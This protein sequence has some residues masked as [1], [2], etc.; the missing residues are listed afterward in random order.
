MSA[1]LA[2]LLP[3]AQWDPSSD[4][5]LDRFLNDAGNPAFLG[6][7]TTV[8]YCTVSVIGAELHFPPG[9]TVLTVQV[10]DTDEHLG[11]PATLVVRVPPSQ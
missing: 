4:V 6:V 9:D 7:G 11:F 8:Q 10:R 3:D 2:D 5:L 1:S